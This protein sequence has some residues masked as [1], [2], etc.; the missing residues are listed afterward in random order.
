MREENSTR[1]ED[2]DIAVEKGKFLKWL[3][4]Y[5]YHYKWVTIGAVFL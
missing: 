5:W 1:L 4:N 2:K 3:D